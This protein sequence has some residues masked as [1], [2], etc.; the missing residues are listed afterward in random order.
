MKNRLGV[1][2]LAVTFALIGSS[3][4]AANGGTKPAPKTAKPP[5]KSAPAAKKATPPPAAPVA[6]PPAPP[7]DLR[8]KSKYTAGDDVTESVSFISDR[9]E[10]FELGDIILIKQRDQKRNVQISRAANT[11]VIV[12]D[13][14]AAQPAATAA[15]RPP[16]VVNVT[17]SIVDLGER[18]DVFGQTAR[19]VRTVIERQPEPGACDQSRLRTETDGWYID[20]PK[21]L[22]AT[23][24]DATPAVAVSGCSDEIKTS[25]SGDAT[26]LGFAI[27]YRTTLTDLADKDAKPAESS[28]EIVEFEVLKIDPSLFELPTGVTAVADAREFT[29]AISDAHE[30]QLASGAADAAVP[31]KKAGTLRVAVPEVTNKTTQTVDT[32][33]LRSR[34]ITELEEQK[35]DAIPLAAAPAADLAAKAKQLGADYLLVAEVTE[36]KTSKPGGLTKMMKAT[37]KEEARDIT[38]AKL[39][40]Q[41]VPPGGKPRLTKNSSGK[42]GGIGLKTTLKVA[43]FAGSVYMKFYMG[44]MLMGQ[45]S[46]FSSLQQMNLGGMGNMGSM[47][48]MGYGNQFDR[49]AGAAN[50]VMQQV[51]AGAAMGA[52]QGGPSYDSALEDAIEDAGK[53]VIESI[54]KASVAKK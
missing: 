24:G 28:M 43:K 34:L 14:A 12:P 13:E 27:G 32:R 17:V 45:M 29:K 19:R 37:A 40:V 52:S 20:T 53:D 15:P 39:N 8:F 41:L 30:A 54:K 4:A 3:I 1:T 7:T 51:V 11:Y 48:P 49:T 35:I 42:D 47:M 22:A 10:R 16:G 9:R 50:F 33:A 18:K 23:A 38:E 31:E 26:L 46:A 5:A 6:P 44:G 21:V 25:A 36:L 2:V